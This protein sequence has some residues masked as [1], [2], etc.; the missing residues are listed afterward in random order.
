MRRFFLRLRSFLRNERVDED[1]D[2]EVAA[3]LALLEDEHRR[4]GLGEREAHLA[5]RRAM[6]SV[7]LAK[8]RHR[9]ARA[10]VWLDDLCRD[11]RF[12]LRLVRRDP[13]FTS[14]AVLTLAL[15]IGATTAIFS[16]VNGVL[17]RPLPYDDS[18]RL[19]RV[20][21]HFA[22]SQTG[23][24]LAPRP[25]LGRTFEPHEV[26]PGSDA[27]VILSYTAWGRYFNGRNDIVGRPLS[28]DGR[29]HTVVGVMPQG[30]EFPDSQSQFWVPLA[31]TTAPGLDTGVS[32]ARIADGRTRG[33]AVAEV[34]AILS[35]VR[36]P[37]EGM[38]QIDGPRFDLLGVRDEVVGP[39][40]RALLILAVAV[41]IVLLLACANVASLQLARAATRQRELAV[42]VAIGAGRARLVR[43]ALT[44]SVTLALMGGVVGTGVAIGLVRLL[45]TFGTSLPR[46]DL[47]AGT[48]IGI[49][50]L[51]EV[52]I[53]TTSLGFAV[54]VSLLTGVVFG[55]APALRQA[56]SDSGQRL[57]DGSG[58][59]R[60][61][62]V[63]VS[64]ELAMAM[65]LLVGG[66]LL[67]NSFIRLSN[68][69]PG[70]DPTNVVW[71]QAFLPRERSAPQVTAFAEGMVE[72][73]GVLPGVIG[74]GY[75]PQIPTGNL[76]RETSLRTT[77]GPPARPPDE[78]T[79]ARV[80]SQGFLTVLGVRVVAGRGFDERDREGQPRVMLINET[81][82]RSPELEGSPIGKRFYTLGEQPWEIIGVVEDIHQFGPDRDPGRQVFVDFRQAPTSGR[83]G[84][85][86]AVRTD[87]TLAGLVSNARS[88]AHNL[89]PLTTLDSV[90][91]M[92]Q[93]LS[94]A[95]SRPRFYAVWF[96]MFAVIA[97]S[98]AV[99]GLYGLMSYAV[100]QRTR[101]VGIRV[102]LGAQRHEVMGLVL[103]DSVVM[104]VVGVASGVAGAAA[105]ARYLD[106]MLFAMTPLDPAT[107][108]AVAVLFV[109][110]ALIASYVPARRAT[111]VDPLVALRTE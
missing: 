34:S 95:S 78:R 9:D 24:P 36:A 18:E 97:V 70:Y 103:K 60:A 46:R 104:T 45:R 86:I 79:D 68:V 89:D 73:L 102:A 1:L 23:V 51:G 65:M 3:H 82:A 109:S 59:P 107:F 81:L 108:A 74:V 63:L 39:V 21:E 37:R 84:L 56:R 91:T 28:L 17:L 6:G 44:E 25:I 88:I 16:L 75:A 22:P 66:G 15:G 100:A 93:L 101:E 8:D 32:I 5:A 54:I 90:A 26:T 98:I 99:I 52:G 13:G 53:D 29:V 7:A 62:R 55:L 111:Q 105:F 72:R 38:P 42:R 14:V 106:G 49:P 71:L 58:S 10:F 94:N 69:D 92:E 85:F 27:V 61:H 76:L 11:L 19:V 33:E 80:V 96:G 110:V 43:Q 50:R 48:G 31:R 83:N 2:R 87:G 64:A 57:R 41:G 67:V 47:Y 12:T 4:R 77:P 40:R 20:A 30:F 35:R